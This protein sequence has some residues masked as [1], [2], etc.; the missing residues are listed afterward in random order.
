MTWEFIVVRIKN[1]SVKKGSRNQSMLDQW[2]TADDQQ[3]LAKQTKYTKTGK[4]TKLLKELQQQFH[5]R[6]RQQKES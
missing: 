1:P 3:N 5:F 6:Q 2:N 4:L